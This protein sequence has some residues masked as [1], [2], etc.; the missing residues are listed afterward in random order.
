[1]NVLSRRIK[2]ERRHLEGMLQDAVQEAIRVATVP[3]S[4]YQLELEKAPAGKK[5]LLLLWKED[6]ENTFYRYRTHSDERVRFDVCRKLVCASVCLSLSHFLR[7][8]VCVL[9]PTHMNHSNPLCVC[10]CVP[11][12]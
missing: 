12:F 9:H 3:V 11:L 4:F 6:T 8:Y 7:V 10:V 1:M 2:V 5:C